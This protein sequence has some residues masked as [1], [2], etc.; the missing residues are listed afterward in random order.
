MTKTFKKAISGAVAAALLMTLG[1]C[2][3]REDPGKEGGETDMNYIEKE[4]NLCVGDTYDLGE[5][6]YTAESVGGTALY[7]VENT[8]TAFA[9]GADEVIVSDLMQNR[10]RYRVTV[11][12]DA[13][14]LG[15]RYVIDRGMFAGKRMIIFG[16]S[17]TDG[18]LL[19]PEKPT[20]YED[21][22]V[23]KLCRY[24]EMASDPTDLENCNFSCGGTTLTYGLRGGYGISGV[25]RVDQ[26]HPF[27]DGGRVRNPYPN[28]LTADFCIIAYGGN[29]FSENVLAGTAENHP[30][31]AE[32][33][34]TIGG[35][36]Y[37]MIHKLR[38]MNPRLKILVLSPNY[39][40]ADGTTYVFSE[41]FTDIR[42][43]K[44]SETLRDYGTV[45][46]ETAEKYGAKFIDL[47][48]I[49]NYEN[50]GRSDASQYTMD[51][52]HPNAAGHEMI[53]QY[54]LKAIS[55]EVRGGNQ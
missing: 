13:A 31:R 30:E 50:Y 40:R 21:M 23:T 41:D 12:E 51:G 8:V 11:Y 26:T 44:T 17:I 10:T 25:E 15:D 7:L 35:G 33:A 9:A 14:A 16:A 52:V 45:M 1:A 29:D 27:T 55:G 34:V 2:G 36:I 49:F 4:L 6:G 53:Y 48:P 39:K 28:I 38:E 22:Y 19:D 20:N 43:L 5:M 46:R 24:L 32:D 54:L 42:N 3:A 18:C 47:Y 37:Y